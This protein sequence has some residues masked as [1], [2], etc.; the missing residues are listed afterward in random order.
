MKYDFVSYI[1]L[2]AQKLIQ[3]PNP[4]YNDTNAKSK[5]FLY[6]TF[7]NFIAKT[8]DNIYVYTVFRPY[9]LEEP[10]FKSD[11]F[12]LFSGFHAKWY[13]KLTIDMNAIQDI[14]NHIKTI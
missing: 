8:F 4:D 1:N 2:P 13:L 14:L 12:N 10:K 11:F 3:M 9:H 5:G 7:P 6:E